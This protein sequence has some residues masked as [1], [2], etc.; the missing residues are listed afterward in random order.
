LEFD[1]PWRQTIPMKSPGL[2][3]Q[4]IGKAPGPEPSFDREIG[5]QWRACAIGVCP[6]G[7]PTTSAIIGRALTQSSTPA[8]RD[9]GFIRD[10]ERDETIGF[11]FHP[12]IPGLEAEFGLNPPDRRVFQPASSFIWSCAKQAE[13][14]APMKLRVSYLPQAR[15]KC[16]QAKS[17]EHGRPRD[18]GTVPGG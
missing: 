4:R 8:N 16:G 11:N 13:S 7:S 5:M 10:F 1:P 15:L 14:P 17:P 9:G 18:S 3:Q 2:E 12:D 6:R